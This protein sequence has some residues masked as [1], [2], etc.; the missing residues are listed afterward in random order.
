[1]IRRRTKISLVIWVVLSGVVFV[2]AYVSVHQCLAR[3]KALV[4]SPVEQT[5]QN[6]ADAAF[7][8]N[9]CTI[10]HEHGPLWMDL[11]RLV[12]LGMFVALPIA[13]VRDFIEWLRARC[14]MR[15]KEGEHPTLS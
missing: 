7:A 3:Q 13:V 12:W 10:L 4:A 11:L 5:P 6:P 9:P 14:R 8:F 2:P 1:M 15:A